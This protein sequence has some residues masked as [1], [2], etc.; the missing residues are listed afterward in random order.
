VGIVNWSRHS[1]GLG[2]VVA[3]AALAVAGC[4][5]GAAG[6][7]A[8]HV[9]TVT[10]KRARDIDLAQAGRKARTQARRYERTAARISR[11]QVDASLDGSRLRLLAS[12]QQAATAY[13]VA[14]AAADSADVGTYS[15]ALV[16]AGES[17]RS[18]QQA[19]SRFRV[20]ASAPVA[21]KD[22]KNGSSAPARPCAGDSVSD[23]PSDDSCS[24]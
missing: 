21:I 1:L 19:L 23:D 11:M 8:S 9:V 17:R 3:A 20:R 5:G 15:A 24:P 13:R 7:P 16:A 4:G 18:V 6:T 22:A 10:S 12:L 14:S 2:V